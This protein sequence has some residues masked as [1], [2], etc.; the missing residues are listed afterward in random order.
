MPGW[1][2][3]GRRSRRTRR[4]IRFRV[5]GREEHAV[6][7]EDAQAPAP[8]AGSSAARIKSS[9]TSARPLGGERVHHEVNSILDEMASRNMRRSWHRFR[10]WRFELD[11]GSRGTRRRAPS[12]VLHRGDQHEDARDKIRSQIRKIGRN[13]LARP[14]ELLGGRSAAVSNFAI[15]RF[16][17]SVGLHR[18]QEARA[19][20]RAL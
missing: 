3:D 7:G 17:Q 18:T 9:A 20:C 15:R 11:N 5:T 6:I 16:L 13:A 8:T 19:R 4:R 14:A 12:V 10:R 1:L 2:T